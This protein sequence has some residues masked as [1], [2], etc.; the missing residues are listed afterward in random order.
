MHASRKWALVGLFIAAGSWAVAQKNLAKTD[1]LQQQEQE[2]L[3]NEGSDPLQGSSYAP[4][5]NLAAQCT[6]GEN[7]CGIIA[8]A[9]DE[10]M[11]DLQKD[12][13]FEAR[14][15]SGE[16]HPDVFLRQ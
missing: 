5:S 11:P 4:A 6:S 2:W 13:D 9:T 1:M 10:G 8:P 15:T 12:Q 16:E 14:I 3:L 7:V